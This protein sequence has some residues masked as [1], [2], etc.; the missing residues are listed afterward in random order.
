MK[1]KELKKRKKRLV[2]LATKGPS[3]GEEEKEGNDEEEV[4]KDGEAR[5]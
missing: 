3:V 1:K 2:K 5:S 4:G